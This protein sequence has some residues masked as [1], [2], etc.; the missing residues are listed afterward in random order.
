MPW[1]TPDRSDAVVCFVVRQ[2]GDLRIAHVVA[3]D[4]R[5]E[6]ARLLMA[7]ALRDY[8][9]QMGAPLGEGRTY[10]LRDAYEPGWHIV[11]AEAPAVDRWTGESRAAS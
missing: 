5:A 2:P 10:V 4:A 6:D 7:A 9:V 1:A 11:C 8:A 3:D